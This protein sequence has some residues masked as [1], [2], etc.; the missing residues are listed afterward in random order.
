M[1][2]EEEEVSFFAGPSMTP[3]PKTFT[4]PLEK[5]FA[6]VS[7]STLIS[8]L[9][10]GLLPEEEVEEALSFEEEAA[11]TIEADLSCLLLVGLEGEFGALDCG[12]KA[13]VSAFRAAFPFLPGKVKHLAASISPGLALGTVRA[14]M[15]VFAFSAASSLLM[16]EPIDEER[17]SELA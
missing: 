2:E 16:N 15:V 17:L 4:V 7:F 1:L 5:T 8:F 14:V 3:P 12:N 11:E 9:E 13:N 10:E 6:S